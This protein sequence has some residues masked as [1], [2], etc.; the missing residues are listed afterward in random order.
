MI[1]PTV[2]R[3]P[4]GDPGLKSVGLEGS[5]SNFA[6]LDPFIYR[7]QRWCG[8]CGGPQLFVEVFECVCGR[9]GVCMGCGDERIVPWSRTTEQ[10]ESSSSREGGK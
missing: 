2:P 9:V 7:D 3:P 5:A 1:S 4:G 8:R 10:F 6:P